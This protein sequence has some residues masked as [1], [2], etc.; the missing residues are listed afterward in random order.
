MIR[1][2]ILV[3]FVLLILT[4]FSQKAKD[5]YVYFK[6]MKAPLTPKADLPKKY[7]FLVSEESVNPQGVKTTLKIHS[8]TNAY[9]PRS[10]FY[11]E[12]AGLGQINGFTDEIYHKD[13]LLFYIKMDVG[14]M[15]DGLRSVVTGSSPSGIPNYQY[16]IP[17]RLPMTFSARTNDTLEFFLRSSNDTAFTYFF[18]KDYK[19]TSAVGAYF[20]QAELGAAYETNRM[21]FL[22]EMRNDIVK[23]WIY[24]TKMDFSSHF[25]RQITDL[26]LDLYF[27]KDKKGEYGD[28]DLLVVKMDTLFNQL[29]ANYEKSHLTN[30]HGSNYKTQFTKLA[31]EWEII[32]NTDSE[33]AKTGGTPRFDTEAKW[34]LYKNYL[35]CKFFSGEIDFVIEKC[36]LLEI[37]RQSDEMLYE[38]VKFANLR[39]F[40]L[41]YRVRY[42]ANPD[43][44]GVE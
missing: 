3:S 6:Y 18:P 8:K 37:D 44:F 43:L 13:S 25:A 19:P 26:R 7:H 16:K 15:D 2:F 12:A 32:L 35:W 1:F 22:V 33:K 36:T 34:G 4:G 14:L 17:F 41:D 38:G 31:S 42:L 28:V 23:K 21:N 30:W 24:Q 29:N 5:R 39:D 20:S 10:N 40:A 27:I 9:D 11:K